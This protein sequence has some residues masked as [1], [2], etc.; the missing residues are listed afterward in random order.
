[1]KITKKIRKTMQHHVEPVER[2]VAVGVQQS[3]SPKAWKEFCLSSNK[4]LTL[5][6]TK[7]S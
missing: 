7:A 5:M 2:L 1:M 3:Y 4:C 6:W